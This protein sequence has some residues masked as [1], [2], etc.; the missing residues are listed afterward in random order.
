MSYAVAAV[1]V[2]GLMLALV[3]LQGTA[4]ATAAGIAGALPLGYAYAAG[5]VASVNPCGFI[6]LP[7]YVSFQLGTEEQG[8][9]QTPP[10]QRAARALLLGV[11][12]TAGFVLVFGSAGLILA[13]GGQWLTEIFPHL[14]V[15][16]GGA[17]A[18]L[19]LWLLITRQTLYLTAATRIS[20]P[21]GNAFV[22]GIGYAIGSLGCTLPIFLVV[23]GGALAGQGFGQ[24]L[25]YS[26]GMG[27][28][29]IAVTLG[30]ALFKGAIGR[31]L[32]GAVPHV[33]RLSAMFLVAAG[34]YLVYYWGVYAR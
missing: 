34:A 11:L 31:T 13:A 32:R 9:Y 27:T 12:A 25:S 26:L 20:T 33:H 18:G 16:V 21:V 8:Y 28:V 7:S 14:G 2:T 30:A 23:V 10:L 29:L 19:G 17:M 4:E 1:L 24:F 22:F 6:L 15:L 5:M 3:A